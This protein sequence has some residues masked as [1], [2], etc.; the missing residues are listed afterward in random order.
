[1]ESTAYPQLIPILVNSL[2]LGLNFIF[3]LLV[4]R[5]FLRARDLIRTVNETKLDIA[6]LT[7][8]FTSFQK[9]EGMRV[10]RATKTTEA[11]I[12]AELKSLTSGLPG[13][14]AADLDPKAALRRKLRG[15]H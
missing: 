3:T 12:A 5:A 8:R 9:R 14:T 7:E 4:L 15:Q 11:D 10:A 6:D 2:T 13:T 1:M